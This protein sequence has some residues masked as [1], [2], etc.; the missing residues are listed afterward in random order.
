M[1]SYVARDRG[2]RNRFQPRPGFLHP[3]RRRNRQGMPE[4]RERSEDIFSIEG[5]GEAGSAGGAELSF[6]D[7]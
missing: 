5:V 4:R 1:R 2:R 3:E 7:R 6:S